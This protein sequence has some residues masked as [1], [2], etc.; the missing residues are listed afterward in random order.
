MSC[1]PANSSVLAWI[2]IRIIG[3]QT[4]PSVD[5]YVELFCLFIEIITKSSKI[6]T[7]PLEL[8]VI[9]MRIDDAMAELPKFRAGSNRPMYHWIYSV[10]EYTTTLL[11]RLFEGVWFIGAMLG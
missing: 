8:N 5:V 11:S 2:R 1:H 4:D 7:F 9:K 3:P 10:L 6:R